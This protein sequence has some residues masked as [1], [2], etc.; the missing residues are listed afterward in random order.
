[1][2]RLCILY[3]MEVID[4]IGQ[5]RHLIRFKSYSSTLFEKD[6]FLRQIHKKKY[7]QY[8]WRY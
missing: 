2:H 8:Q 7:C 4:E 1:M 5:Y 6:D 3:A